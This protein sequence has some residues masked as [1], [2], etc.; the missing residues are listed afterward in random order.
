MRVHLAFE[1]LFSINYVSDED[2]PYA[3]RLTIPEAIYVQAVNFRRNQ[4]RLRKAR[5]KDLHS[6]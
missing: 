4:K 5:A 3:C 1:N 6:V 2:A